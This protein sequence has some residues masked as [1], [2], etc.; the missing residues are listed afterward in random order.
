MS[1][2]IRWREK[3]S[4]VPLWADTDGVPH[5]GQVAAAWRGRSWTSGSW[6]DSRLFHQSLHSKVEAS[7]IELQV[8]TH[9]HFEWLQ[10]IARK[11]QHWILQVHYIQILCHAI[12]ASA[13]WSVPKWQ[14]RN[15]DPLLLCM[16]LLWI[17]HQVER[18]RNPADTDPIVFLDAARWLACSKCPDFC[19]SSMEW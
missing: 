14:Y 6:I 12:Y 13:G 1:R 17:W 18:F 2:G 10:N 16:A 15:A 11:H 9:R 7:F 8:A 19:L 4:M 3:G 5:E